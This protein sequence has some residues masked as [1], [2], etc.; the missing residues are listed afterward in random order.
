[1]I[2]LLGTLQITPVGLGG[3]GGGGEGPL[4]YVIM[5][6]MTMAPHKSD[7]QV[8]VKFRSIGKSWRQDITAGEVYGRVISGEKRRQREGND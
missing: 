3:G 7:A 4:W 2:S 8:L 5:G 1:M 6:F